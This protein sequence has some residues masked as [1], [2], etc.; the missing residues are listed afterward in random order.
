MTEE[1]VCPFNLAVLK[2]DC[3]QFLMLFTSNFYD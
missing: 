3:Q 1:Y 2:C